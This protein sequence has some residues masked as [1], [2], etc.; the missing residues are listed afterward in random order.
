MIHTTHTQNLNS[1]IRVDNWTQASICSKY[2]LSCE[3]PICNAIGLHP[4]NKPNTNT[5]LCTFKKK[6]HN[7]D[8]GY[9]Y[10]L[11][12]VLLGIYNQ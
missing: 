9:P 2:L 5:K 3:M 10:W 1:A 6:Q 7:F 11:G 8:S 4:I 12:Y